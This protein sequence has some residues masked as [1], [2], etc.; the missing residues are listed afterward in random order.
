MKPTERVTLTMRELDRLKVI[1]SVAD[2]TQTRS[3]PSGWSRARGLLRLIIAR[4]R[5]I[6]HFSRPV[7][8]AGGYIGD[9]GTGFVLRDGGHR[10]LLLYR[11]SIL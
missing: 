8:R 7:R 4:R 2:A 10:V 5:I 6:W 9:I 3:Q 1:Q 11:V